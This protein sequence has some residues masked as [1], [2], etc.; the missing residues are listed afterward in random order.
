[1]NETTVKV[2]VLMTIKHDDCQD[3]E[4]IVNEMDYRFTS[5]EALI[6]NTEIVSYEVFVT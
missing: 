4:D 5:D 1:M 6:K 2:E 3:P